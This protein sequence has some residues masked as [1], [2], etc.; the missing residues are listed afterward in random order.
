MSNNIFINILKRKKTLFDMCAL[1]N[2]AVGS[3]LEFKYV[4]SVGGIR[5][6]NP[7]HISRNVV[8]LK[9]N[10]SRFLKCVLVHIYVSIILKVC[11]ATYICKYNSLI[12]L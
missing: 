2:V 1:M 4:S 10:D 6:Y 8:P 12:N 5:K 7:S 11:I 3:G 9:T